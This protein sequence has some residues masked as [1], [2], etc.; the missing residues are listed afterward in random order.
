MNQN[1]DRTLKVYSSVYLKV[2]ALDF[3]WHDEVRVQGALRLSRGLALAAVAF[4]RQAISFEPR[5]DGDVGDYCAT[6]PTL[7]QNSRTLNTREL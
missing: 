3:V 6:R 4:P 7:K 1:R 5:C 2:V